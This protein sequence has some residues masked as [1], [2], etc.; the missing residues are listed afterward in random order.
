MLCRSGVWV[1]R[2]PLWVV[3]G[4][5]SAGSCGPRLAVAPTW[6]MADW[7][8]SCDC[9][10]PAAGGCWWAVPA[11]RVCGW[12]G[13]RWWWSAPWVRGSGMCWPSF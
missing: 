13:G 11:G 7:A 1:S 8:S 10:S 12:G 4:C 5:A 6:G 9:G 2:R 3:C